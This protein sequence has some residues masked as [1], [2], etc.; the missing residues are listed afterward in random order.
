MGAPVT[1]P[2]VAKIMSKGMRAHLLPDHATLDIID[3][4]HLIEHDPLDVAD[5]I[6]ALVQHAAQDL[7]GHDQAR[8]LRLDAHIPGQQAH[9]HRQVV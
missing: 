8:G 7:G 9:L 1:L 4:V 2:A 3:I 5:D 6:G